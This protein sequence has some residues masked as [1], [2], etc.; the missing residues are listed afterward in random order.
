MKYFVLLFLVYH[1]VALIFLPMVV[2]WFIG[3][4]YEIVTDVETEEI[5]IE[6]EEDTILILE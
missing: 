1:L 6:I 3:S 5:E 4:E 2:T